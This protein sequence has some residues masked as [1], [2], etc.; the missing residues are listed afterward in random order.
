MR[1]SLVVRGKRKVMVTL[2]V[3]AAVCL[4]AAAGVSASNTRAAGSCTATVKPKDVQVYFGVGS[5][6]SEYWQEVLKGAKAVMASLGLKSHFHPYE[7]NFDGQKLLNTF[8]SILAKGGKG[9]AL[10]ADPASNAYTRPLVQLAQQSGA[11]VVTLW[12]RPTEIHPWD[13]GGGCWVA[14]TAFDGVEGG[15]KNAQ[16]LFTALHGKGNIT[17]LL[18]IPD[19]PSAKQRLYGL[20]Q[21]L[22]AFPGITLLDS[23][24]GHWQPT[25]AQQITQTWVGKYGSQINGIWTANDGMATGA[26][27]ALRSNSLNGKIPVTGSD[28]SRDV[29]QLIAQGDMLSTMAVDAYSQGAVA[30]ALAYAA[31]VGDINVSKL[32]HKQRDFFLKQT[33]VTKANVQAVLN[34][35]FSAAKFN[36]TKLKKNFWYDV[37]TGINDATWIPNV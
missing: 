8:T 30:V 32:T 17:A 29:L 31:T 27:E 4:S 16:A 28:G 10:V 3:V 23:Q 15:I 2:V 35:K 18:G 33:L 24:V 6:S 25:E 9:V 7:D 5:F 34:A 37:S 19:D 13:T 14:H 36:Y 22:K 26:V 11:R 12:N 21:E 20:K 1:R